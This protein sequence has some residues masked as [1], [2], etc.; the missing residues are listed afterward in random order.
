MTEL[1]LDSDTI[2]VLSVDTRLDILKLLSERRRTATEL[3]K[4]LEKHVTTIRTHLELLEKAQLVNR[5]ENNHKWV[6]FQLTKKGSMLVEPK[7]MTSMR[8][9]FTAA[10]ALIGYAFW[11]IFVMLSKTRTAGLPIPKALEK[12][13]TAS[14]ESAGAN[15]AAMDGARSAV[16]QATEPASIA[17]IFDP[18]LFL[19]VI[20]A[21]FL[22]S[23]LIGYIFSCKKRSK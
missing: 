5:I 15:D 13:Y 11:G 21:L 1:V 19:S 8:F 14:I 2:K 9:M 16:Q 18:T 10:A 6:Y 23:V 4:N 12:T 7:P 3:S 20:L 17:A 22:G